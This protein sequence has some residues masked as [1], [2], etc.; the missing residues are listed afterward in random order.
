MLT[1]IC[2]IL[3]GGRIMIVEDYIIANDLNIFDKQNIDLSN[4]WSARKLRK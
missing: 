2:N 1:M 4:D 3:N